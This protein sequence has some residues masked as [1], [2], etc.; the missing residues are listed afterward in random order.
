MNNAFGK[1]NIN[2]TE[3]SVFY[4]FDP[5]SELSVTNTFLGVDLNRDG[6]INSD[7]FSLEVTIGNEFEP[8]FRFEDVYFS[9]TKIDLSKKEITSRKRT[10]SEYIRVEVEVG[11]MLPDFTF[12]DFNEQKRTL[13]DF[14]GKYV[15]VDF[16]G[17][18]CVDCRYEI[19][20][21]VEA[22][23]RFKSRGLEILSLNTDESIDVAKNYISKNNI[24]WTQ[25]KFESIKDL[26][27]KYYAIENYP[28][29]ILLDPNGKVIIINQKK[30]R[31]SELWQTLDQIL[32]K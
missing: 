14:K 13:N 10:A 1:I 16:W 18:W 19:P 27:Q 28:T 8:V 21:Q 17:V 4:G 3:L 25:A 26:A 22:Y 24:T 31:D 32:P 15:L 23:K 29:S 2:N 30:L 20:Y 12:T 9:T 6:K 11:R 5:K 7:T